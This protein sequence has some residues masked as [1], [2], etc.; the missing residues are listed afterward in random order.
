M[1]TAAFLSSAMMVDKTL[2]TGDTA[3]KIE[4]IDGINVGHDATSEKKAKL[5]SFWTPKKPE[6]RISNRNL[7]VEYRNKEGEEVEFISIC[8]DSDDGLMKEVMKTDGVQASR[9]YS[10][11]EINPRVF[12]DYGADENPR[13]FLISVDG[14]IVEIL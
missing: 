3:P 14:K 10:A 13:A 11:K 5:I 1:L 7:S 2:K 8:T 12:K 9:I 4:T 6:S